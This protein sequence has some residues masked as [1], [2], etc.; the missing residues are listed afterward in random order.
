MRYSWVLSRYVATAIIQANA[1]L[2]VAQLDE[3][4]LESR[5]P[6]LAVNN[7]D[8]GSLTTS[9]TFDSKLYK[10][11]VDSFLPKCYCRVQCCAASVMNAQ[12]HL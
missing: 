5:S 10:F 12:W 3:A 4:Q 7:P 9:M 2:F 8:I 6:Q 11:A 1:I